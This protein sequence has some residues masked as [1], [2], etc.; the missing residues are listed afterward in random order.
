VTRKPARPWVARARSQERNS[1][2]DNWYRRQA[3]CKLIAPLRTA[4]TTAAFRRITHLRVFAG[5]RPSV[6][7][8]RINSSSKRVSADRFGDVEG[9]TSNEPGPEVAGCPRNKVLFPLLLSRSTGASPAKTQFPLISRFF[10]LSFR[11]CHLFFKGIKKLSPSRQVPRSHQ[12]PPKSI[13]WFF[14]IG[15]W[16]LPQASPGPMRSESRARGMQPPCRESPIRRA[17]A[18][19]HN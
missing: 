4:P 5:G 7:D 3:S 2:S 8:I 15:V 13:G 6:R 1:S 14:D 10:A 17:A 16:C 19:F 18:C 9:L 11:V 12:R